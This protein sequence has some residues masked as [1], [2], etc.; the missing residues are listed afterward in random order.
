MTWIILYLINVHVHVDVSS[1]MVEIWWKVENLRT[2]LLR[3]FDRASLA[4]ASKALNF[5]TVPVAGKQLKQL[6]VTL[7]HRATCVILFLEEPRGSAKK[8]KT[9]LKK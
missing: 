7:P 9:L 5:K 1:A 8:K 2:K 4:L 3:S 6:V